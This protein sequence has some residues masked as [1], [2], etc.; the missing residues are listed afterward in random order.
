MKMSFDKFE[1]FE[2]PQ[3]ILCN[4]GSRYANG[5]ISLPVGELSNFTDLEIILNFG[6]PSDLN[7]RIHY[8]PQQ[9]EDGDM[10]VRDL[11]NKISNRRMLFLPDIGF[12]SIV[13]MQEHNDGE[14]KYKDVTAKSCDYEL[15]RKNIPYIQDGTYKLYTANESAPGI[16]DMI[17][18]VAPSWSIG[19]I[20]DDLL[21]IYRTFTEVD[22]ETNVL[23]FLTEEVQ[24]A[25][26]CVITYDTINRSISIDAM[27]NYENKT[28][29]HLSMDDLVTEVNIA[30]DADN[31]YTALRVTTSDEISLG[32]VNPIGGNVI[33]NFHYYI[34]WMSPSLKSKMTQWESDMV[35]A[36]QEYQFLGRSYFELVGEQSLL[37]SEIQRL[38]VLLDIYQTCKENF[39]EGMQDIPIDVY[40]NQ[41][42]A[43]GG[44][45]IVVYDTVAQTVAALD[46]QLSTTAAEK[47]STEAELQ[48]VNSNMVSLDTEIQS[49][50]ERVSFKTILT[51]EEYDELT[52]YVFEGNYTDEYIAITSSMSSG[53]IFDQQLSMY[54]RAKQ[55][56]NEIA[57][58]TTEFSIN[59][60]SFVFAKDFSEITDQIFPGCLIDVQTGDRDIKTLFLTGIDVNYEER[61]ATLSFGNRVYRNDAKALFDKVLGEI[62]VSPNTVL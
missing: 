16:L 21:N 59:T 43:A 44:S 40:N 41:I 4:P 35:L 25:Y 29:V 60:V 20:D 12:F 37:M 61:E 9:T 48:D 24:K 34:D 18:N 17:L 32:S 22:T 27:E 51:D 47:E 7:F 2:E 28:D 10:F 58:P 30:E 6:A 62:S 39:E 31:L 19:H 57:V 45:P 3:I 1:R 50:R 23:T 15:G 42:D 56:L 33:Y 26:E 46:V 11:Y 52:C 5:D 36:E 55:K 8:V 54:I 49:V 38:D 53:E 14:D 13:S